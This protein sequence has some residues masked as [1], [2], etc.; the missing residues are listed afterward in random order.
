MISY[1][2]YK[3]ESLYVCEVVSL[4]FCTHEKTAQWIWMNFYKRAKK[5]TNGQIAYGPHLNIGY[6]VKSKRDKIGT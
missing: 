4:Y 1:L 6:I 5:R 2:Y 3:S